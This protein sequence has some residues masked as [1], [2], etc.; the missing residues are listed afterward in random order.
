MLQPAPLAAHADQLRQFRSWLTPL[1]FF[2][3]GLALLGGLVW[4]DRPTLIMSVEIAAYG[5][6]T[7]V[8]RAQAASGQVRRAG[9]VLGVGIVLTAL[10]IV[11]TRPSLSPTLVVIPL[12]G[13]AVALPYAEDRTFRALP[14]KLAGRPDDRRPGRAGPAPVAAAGLVHDLLQH[15]VAGSRCRDGAAAALALSF[16][17][18]AVTPLDSA[19]LAR[20]GPPL[21]TALP[22]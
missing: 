4:E 13:V 8:A 3:A 10:L 2:F 19:S 14:G 21:T 22:A 17:A 1:V 7:L 12:L 9:L 20:A 6:L 15:L 11:A 5:V 18:A 16:A